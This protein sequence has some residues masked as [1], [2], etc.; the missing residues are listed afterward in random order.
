MAK[1]SVRRGDFL[2]RSLDMSPD[3]TRLAVEAFPAPV[4]GVLLE[5][6]PDETV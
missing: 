4:L 2:E 6:V 5:V 1:T 3:F